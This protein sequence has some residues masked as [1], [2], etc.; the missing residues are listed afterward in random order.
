MIARDT[1]WPTSEKTRG[2]LKSARIRSPS[3][4][5]T[6]FRRKRRELCQVGTYLIARKWIVNIQK[7]PINEQLLDVSFQVFIWPFA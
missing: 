6:W 3:S 2:V 1:F 4:N 5:E 7:T